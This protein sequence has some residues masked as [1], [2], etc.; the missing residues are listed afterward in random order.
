L[1]INDRG[2]LS[3]ARNLTITGD[4]AIDTATP[5]AKLHVRTSSSGVKAVAI[6]ENSADGTN[7]GVETIYRNKNI[8]LASIAATRGPSNATSQL[9]FSTKADSVFSPKMIIHT[10]G[11]VA[12]GKSK[13]DQRLHVAGNIAVDG[14]VLQN[15]DRRLK[16]S[17][18]PLKQSLLK[19]NKISGVE[20]VWRDRSLSQQKQYGF[21]AQEIKKVFPHL[22]YKSSDNGHLSVNY[23]GFIPLLLESIKQQDDIIK[24]N[25]KMI[26]QMRREI[27]VM[28]RQLEKQNSHRDKKGKK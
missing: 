4:L 3:V 27:Q 10:N 12:I 7:R 16:K 9:T 14:V 11:G 21:I 19:L 18:R 6:I 28:M 13:P 23:Q 20:F 5:G 26:V 8:V 2:D 24:E 17:I 22:V 1:D 15:S 25:R